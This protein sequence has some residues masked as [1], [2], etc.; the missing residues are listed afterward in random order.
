MSAL[1]S[2][3]TGSRR[4]P[5]KGEQGVSLIITLLLLLLLTAMS[6]TM[7]LSV[8][9]DMLVNGYYRNSRGS[10]YAADSGANIA[11]QAFINKVTS[12]VLPGFGVALAP[13]P[14]NEAATAQA[15]M[16]TTYGPTSAVPLNGG[17]S[18]NSWPEKFM[19]AKFQIVPN[20]NTGIIGECEPVGGTP[21]ATCAKP[22]QDPTHAMKGYQYTYFYTITSVG[23]SKGTEATSLLDQGVIVFNPTIQPATPTQTNFAAFGMFIDQ[24]PIC[25]GTT[26]VQGTITGPVFTNGAWNFGTGN[27]TYTDP[28]GSVSPTACFNGTAG[29]SSKVPS[30]VAF[31]QG[32]NVGL[33]AGTGEKPIPLPSNSFN[34][35]QA[36]LDGVGNTTTAPGSAALNAALKD[37][38]KNPWGGSGKTIVPSTTGVYLPYTQNSSGQL[39]FNGG[40]IYVQGDASVLLTPGTGSAQVYTISQG[41]GKTAVTT[42]IT[43][44]PVSN[45]TVI[46]NGSSKQT[47]SGVPQQVDPSG[48]GS[49]DAAMLYV[50]GNITALSGPTQPTKAGATPLPAIQNGTELTITAAQNIT[51]TGDIRY[52]TEPVTMTGTP[53]DQLIPANDTHQVL[54]IFTAGGNVQLNNLQTS[55]NLEID[56]SIATISASGSGGI[57]NI[58]SNTSGTLNIVGGRIQNTIQNI[59]FANR[60]VFFDRRFLKGG[61]SPPWFPSTTVQP[62]AGAVNPVFGQPV[63]LRTQWLN[64]TSSY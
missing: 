14:A 62:G 54:G 23:Q 57:V 28:V 50:N 51:I 37:A 47:I 31:Q 32:W 59:A 61:F 44:D 64:Q 55:G 26:L 43:I 34:Q 4:S 56:A 53:P 9:S 29:N 40:G 20:P 49:T 7:V 10:F 60:N 18:A 22:G 39:V 15:Y 30:N 45:T 11:R 13:L 33:A 17:Q 12:D 52:T 46:D 48:L 36:V 63:I 41:S 58:G 16:A 8:S 2:L 6:L 25:N 38:S 5:R 1:T 24:S 27:Y 3:S 19:L 21:G 42:T 35:E